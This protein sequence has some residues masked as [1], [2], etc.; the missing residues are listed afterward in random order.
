MSKH[1]PGPWTF[2]DDAGIYADGVAIAQVYGPDD[3]ACFSPNTE[4]EQKQAE[5]NCEANGHLI[6]AAPDLLEACRR[7]VDETVNTP[8]SL[9]AIECCRVAIQ[10]AEGRPC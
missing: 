6:A 10:K 4:D 3:F 5:T 1:T 2:D 8:P 7:I 9:G